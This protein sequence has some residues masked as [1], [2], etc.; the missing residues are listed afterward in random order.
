[1][2]RKTILLF[3]LFVIVGVACRQQLG[4]TLPSQTATFS[5]TGAPASDS[6]D[7]ARQCRDSLPENRRFG[8]NAWHKTNFCLHSVPYEEFRSGGVGR[9]SI[10]SLDAPIFESVEDGNLWLADV[11][12]VLVLTLG[13]D[14]RAYPLSILIWHEI[15]NDVVE[16]KP[17]VVTY[18]PLCSSGLI[19]TRDV[20]GR[21]LDFGTTGNL[22]NAD[23]IMY[24]RQ[25]ESWWQQFTGE[26]IVGDMTGEQLTILPSAVVS[27]G[28]FKAQ[29][30]DGLVLSGDTGYERFYGETPYINY[31]S[32]TNPRAK[33][34]DGEL[35]RRLP[36]KMHLLGVKVG[37]VAIAY[38]YS[39][40]SEVGV[41]N[42]EQNG[43]PLVIFWK[44]GTTSPLYKKVIAESRDVGSAAAFS[45][46]VDDMTLTFLWNGEVFV[47]QETN[48]TWNLFGTAVAGPLKGQ[49]LSSLSGHEF[50]WFAWV[51]FEPDTS[52]YAPPHRDEE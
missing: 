17:I 7:D 47:D 43:Q 49:Q 20:K 42:D 35:D 36:T 6:G 9:D 45:R 50:L 3:V 19:F 38:P 52:L 39:L 4:T 46:I 48:S 27:W 10:P 28:D 2:Q 14:S 34:F 51:A 37:D 24:D 8:V 30:P 33:F 44:A 25:T 1:M 16:G 23:L 41:V 40:L 12:P 26:A 21:I 13:A 22:R 15:V 31:D 29:Y 5:S 11:E 18:C 32:L